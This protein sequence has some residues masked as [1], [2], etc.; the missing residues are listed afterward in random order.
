MTGPDDPLPI[1]FSYRY[2][3]GDPKPLFAPKDWEE[4]RVFLQAGNEAIGRFYDAC[5]RGHFENGEAP[6]TIDLSELEA[7]GKPKGADGLPLQYPF[8][9]VFGCSDAR[10]PTEILFGQELNDVFNIRVAGNVVTPGGE[11]SLVFALNSFVDDGGVLPRT[12]KIIVAL[13]HR[14]CGAV[15]GAVRAYL[16]SGDASGASLPTDPL[17]L[18]L[19]AIA[20]PPLALAAPAFDALHG[21]GASR[22]PANFARLTELTVHVNAAWVGMRLR[23]IVEAAGEDVANKVGVVFGVADPDD[24]RVRS[25][26]CQDF[27]GNRHLLET[28]PADLEGLAEFARQIASEV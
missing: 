5:R 15:K 26:P 16:E 23:G 7:L 14:G 2:R 4:A 13:G 19:R 8:A 9:V 6:P 24:Q 18:L 12:L 10:V 22:D 25:H 17:G 11:G 21:P 28:P 27:A 3:P 20:N 1:Q